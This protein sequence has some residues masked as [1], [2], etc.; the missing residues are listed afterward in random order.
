MTIGD[1]T[2]LAI[3]ELVY[4]A[5]AW[6]DYAINHTTTPQTNIGI[7]LH[8][9]DPGDSG[10][11]SSNEMGLSAYATYTRVNKTRDNNATTGWQ[12]AAS[13]SISPQTTIA[14]PAGVG[15]TGTS[16]ATHFATA[17]SNATPPTGAQV[18]LWSGTI[19]PNIPC[20]NGVTPQ[21]LNTSTITLD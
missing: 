11:A 2:E 19:T 7:S 3:L 21:L 6:T 10:T 5:T 18:I 16:T 15:G 8:T 14:F 1:T 12:A 20:G 13:G 4:R 17:K 9:S